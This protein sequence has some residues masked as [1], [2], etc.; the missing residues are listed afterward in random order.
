GTV[1][2]TASV[3][4]VVSTTVESVVLGSGDS[5]GEESSASVVVLMLPSTLES[6]SA[7]PG[8]SVLWPGLLSAATATVPKSSDSAAPVV[9]A[10]ARR[11]RA[12]PTRRFH[13]ANPPLSSGYG[14]LS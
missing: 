10:T 11:R 14:P 12:C 5:T 1:V 2:S 7:L 6:S 8:T 9:H 3:T 4:G 13:A